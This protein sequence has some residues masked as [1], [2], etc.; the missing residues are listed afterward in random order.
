MLDLEGN[1]VVLDGGRRTRGA[2]RRR[3]RTSQ[4]GSSGTYVQPVARLA[5]HGQARRSRSRHRSSTAAASGSGSSPPTSTSSASTGSSS[6]RRV[7]ATPARRTSSGPTG[8][9][10]TRASTRRY[11]N[12]VS[13][14]GIDAAIAGKSGRGLYT[15]LRGVPVIGVYRWLDEVGAGL[16]AEQSQHA[17]FAPRADAGADARRRSVSLV[18]SLLAVGD[19]HRRRAASRARSWRSPTR[20][21]RSRPAT[22][23]REAPVT[24]NDEVGTLAVAFNTMTS[25]LRETLEGLEQR[26]AERT[27]ELAE[28]NV[29]LEALH[30]TT[31]GVM[32]RLDLDELLRELIERAGELLGRRHGYVYLARP[33]RRGDRAPRRDRAVRGR[34]RPADGARRGRRRADVWATGEPLVV[35][36]YDAWDGRASRRSRPGTIRG[37]RGRSALLRRGRGRRARHRPR[38]RPTAGLRRPPRSSCSSGSRSSRRSRSTTRASTR[39]A[40]EAREAADAANAAKSSVPGDHEPRDPHADE[41]RHRDERAAAAQR[42][43]RGPARATRRSSARA[44]RRC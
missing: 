22:S 16:V 18:A 8:T 33:G 28:Q 20:R 40:Q 21:R 23:T 41:R 39:A 38:H 26:V 11:A 43:R 37:A 27:E 2:T 36:D 35:D 29:E 1:I 4:R 30:E 32:H 10:C 17:A 19:L 34:A 12:G 44:A 5:A 24:T 25:R 3:R 7:S 14:D 31:L 9:S 15:Q 6:R 42:A 13:S